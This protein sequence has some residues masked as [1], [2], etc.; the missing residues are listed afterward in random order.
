VEVHEREPL[1]AQL[2]RELATSRRKPGRLVL[3]AG[4]AGIGKTTLADAF[5]VG[6]EGGIQVLWGS[7]DAAV[8]PRPFAPLIDIA[9]A[10]EGPLRAALVAADR[11][12]VFE[13]F[14]E[15][16]RQPRRS[17]P[18]I[19]LEDVHWADEGTLDLLRVVGRRLRNLP[20]LV[21]ATYRDVEVARTHPLRRALGDVPSDVV[22]EIRVPPLSIDAVAAMTRATALDPEEVHRS[23]AGNPFFVTELIAT[24]GDAVPASVRDAVL[25]RVGRLSGRG[26]RVIQALSVL[27]QPA[28]LSL[29]HDEGDLQ[30]SDLRERLARVVGVLDRSVLLES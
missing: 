17:P 26:Q 3:I 2:K 22:T 18:V 11:D 16:L 6:L 13:A 10:V 12:R 19:V 30:P 27:A 25:A 4:E 29:V 23:T 7:C 15:L 5:C 24:G 9:D 8:P 20:A 21:V 28:E 1:L 14:L